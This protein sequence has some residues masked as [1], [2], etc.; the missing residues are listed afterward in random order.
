[1]K[2]NRFF[3]A[4]AIGL[5][6]LLSF[7][8]LAQVAI[9]KNGDPPDAS[10]IVDISS[11]SQGLLIPRMTTNEISF[12]NN[13]ANGLIVYNI[14][15][16]KLYIYVEGIGSW[17]EVALD[18]GEIAPFTCGDSITDD[19]DG[20][21][22]ATV[23]AG[24]HCWMAQNL[25]VGSRITGGVAMTNNGTIEK[26]CNNNTSGYCTIYGALYQ[27]DELMNYTTQEGSQ[28][29]CPLGW[30]VPTSQEW[31]TLEGMADS[32]YGIGDPVWDN[33][34]W[35][36]F[37]AGGNLKETGFTHWVSPN[38]GATNST[39]FNLL[40]S[41]LWTGST[42]SLP[43]YGTI[44][45]TSTLN[46]SVAYNRNIDYNHKTISMGTA[47]LTYGLPVR[48]LKNTPSD[49]EP[50]TE[51]ANPLPGNSSEFINPDT[52]LCWDP[53]TD[54]ESDPVTYDVYLGTSA[55]PP[56][57]ASDV[58]DTTFDPGTLGGGLYYWKIVA[59]DYTNQTE[60]PVW[61]FTTCGATLTDSRDSQT[62]GTVQIGD[63]CWMSKNLNVGDTIYNN[64]SPSDNSI[65]EK[66]CY[67]NDLGNCD[68][69]GGLYKWNEM[70][71]YATTPGA[72]GICPDGWHL[73]ANEEWLELT[74]FL[75]GLSVAGG[76][77][78][79]AGISH[80]YSP[81][82]G[83]TNESGFTA[84]P[85]GYHGEDGT[86]G[87]ITFENT[88]WSSTQSSNAAYRIKLINISSTAYNGFNDKLRGVSVRCVKDE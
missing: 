33:T 69:Y 42:W 32:Q 83:G 80:W 71:G 72:Q 17:K 19:R 75:G 25:N 63:K 87:N 60:G 49:N 78:K 4:F 53:S 79:E 21:K 15:D 52:V 58:S 61:T 65:I 1:M 46:G 38:T 51:P 56:L 64:N 55:D 40:P 34:G 66:Y 50:P 44:M 10:A 73:P 84:L 41:G 26:Y 77:L 16:N 76:K 74:D 35:R 18:T 36:G 86:F 28:G 81:N 6:G 30:H 11:D 67:N 48:C 14:D 45:W 29:I 43:G 82:T 22:Y 85:A 7:N 68:T 5:I 88:L 12:I 70:M 27:W 8:G 2:N 9:N 62:Y 57:L 23:L 54:P 37:D 13:P 39:G 20:Q 59:K 24:T 31:K 47:A 3:I